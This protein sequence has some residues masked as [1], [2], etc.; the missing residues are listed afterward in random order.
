MLS[1]YWGSD[2]SRLQPTMADT[3]AER[4]RISVGGRKLLASRPTTEPA[5]SN[6]SQ[7][8]YSVMRVSS[9][10]PGDSAAM[11]RWVV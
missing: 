5:E 2:D 8:P 4:H 11:A 7:L 10:S 1:R 6:N 9:G 3:S